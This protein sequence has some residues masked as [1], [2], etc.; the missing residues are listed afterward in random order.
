MAELFHELAGGNQSGQEDPAAAAELE[1][2][3][4]GADRAQ[5]L[6]HRGRG[7]A[8]EAAKAHMM[9]VGEILVVAA[10]HA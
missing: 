4:V 8:R 6:D 2:R 7:V 1:D 5:R 9:N 10:W 3:S